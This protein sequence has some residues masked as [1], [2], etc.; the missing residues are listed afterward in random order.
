MYS[1][2]VMNKKEY[3]QHVAFVGNAQEVRMALADFRTV[4]KELELMVK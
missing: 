2:S 1:M 3:K 4:L